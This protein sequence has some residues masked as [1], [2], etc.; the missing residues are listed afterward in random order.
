MMKLLK[1]NKVMWIARDKYGSLFIFDKKPKKLENSWWVM[2]GT[3]HCSE[4]DGNMFSEV[5][6]EDEEP[7]ELILKSLKERNC[8]DNVRPLHCNNCG[9]T[10]ILKHAWVDANT[11]E[12]AQEDWANNE[13]WCEDCMEIVDIAE[14]EEIDESNKG[15]C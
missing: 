14:E 11:L 12:F 1:K 5:K 7:R 6:W 3:F 15:I 13:Y 4:I 8:K 10:N 9:G 2:D